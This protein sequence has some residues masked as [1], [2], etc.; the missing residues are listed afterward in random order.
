MGKKSDKNYETEFEFSFEG[1]GD[2]LRGAA[3]KLEMG[4]QDIKISSF[5]EAIDEAT[6]AS[7]SLQG[8]LGNLCVEALTASKNLI[9]ADLAYIG[10]VEFS[11]TG[12]TEKVIRLRQRGKGFRFLGNK[13]SLHWNVRLSPDLPLALKL[14]GGVGKAQLDLTGLNLTA[15]ALHGVVAKTQISLPEAEEG[16]KVHIHGNVGQI[17]I[18]L[19][20]NTDVKLHMHGSVGKV[21]INVPE[22]AGSS[23]VNLNGSVGK[24]QVVVPQEAAVKVVANGC[25][26]KVSTPDHFQRRS[27]KRGF[28]DV[29]GTWETEGFAEAEGRV[30]IRAQGGV[31]SVNVVTPEPEMVEA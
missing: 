30:N 3:S 16:Y 19:P 8:V 9:E 1:V 31:G 29:R 4:D 26:G 28:I 15:L 12:D 6:S 11:A 13:D 14:R 25:L 18:D 2:K 27:K 17:T 5:S 22:N 21:F 7:V 10:E 23:D 20:Q 24:V